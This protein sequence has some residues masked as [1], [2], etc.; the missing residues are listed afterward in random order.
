M[1]LGIMA[2][3]FPPKKEALAKIKP[4]SGQLS[5]EDRDEY[6]Q[7]AKK[8]G[9]DCAELAIDIASRASTSDQLR[10]FLSENGICVYD[11]QRVRRYMDSITPSGSEW[12][13]AP[14]A[15]RDPIA[16]WDIPTAAYRKAIPMPVLM[17]IAKI[18]EAFPEA[19]FFVTDI[20]RL[21]KGDPFLSVRMPGEELFIIERWDE[22]GFRM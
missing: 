12:I 11:R 5:R 15:Y 17:T 19:E 8:A 4:A 16:P 21:P 18:R 2:A 14:I 22:P 9:F 7:W 13:W 10:N 1:G 3:L 6:L 20:R